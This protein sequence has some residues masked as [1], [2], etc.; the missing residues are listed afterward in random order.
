MC[1]VPRREEPGGNGKSARIKSNSNNEGSHWV[2]R[3]GSPA[4]NTRQRSPQPQPRAPGSWGGGEGVPCPWCLWVEQ[5]GRRVRSFDFLL[6]RKKANRR[7]S[8]TLGKYSATSNQLEAILLH[9]LNSWRLG[10][11]SA[12]ALTLPFT[13]KPCSSSASF[14]Q[15]GVAKHRS[16]MELVVM[17]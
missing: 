15:T 10:I 6:L 9:T 14:P 1:S 16:I 5:A 3:V 11:P 17:L 8:M 12:D 7:G 13:L 2:S 4:E